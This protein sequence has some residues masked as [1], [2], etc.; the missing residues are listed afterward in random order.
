VCVC[1]CDL[2]ASTMRRPRLAVG[3]LLHRKMYLVIVKQL[4][5][6]EMA[7]VRKLALVA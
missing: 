1:V 4:L 7:R 6:D 5:D 3:L 2:E